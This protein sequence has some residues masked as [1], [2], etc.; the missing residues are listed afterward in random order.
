M[1]YFAGV[2]DALRVTFVQMMLIS[3]LA[4]GI[5]VV[6]MYINLKKWG[7]GS[8]GYGAAPSKSIMAFPKMLMYQ[9]NEHAHVHNQSVLETFVLDILFQRRILRRSPLRWFMHFTIFVGWMTLF[10]MSGAMFAVE[11]IHLIGEKVGY[12]HSLPWFMIP[13]TFRELLA[14][15]NDV[16]SYIL[17]IGIIIAIYR[18]LFVTKVREATIAYDSILLIGLTII[19][20]SGFV[21]DGI[22]TGR[23]WGLGIDSEL[24]PPMALFHVVISLLF[25]IAYI[26]FSKYIHVIAIPLA[27]LANKGGE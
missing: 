26:P 1:D 15:P 6:G 11:M 24:A 14:V 3:F 13:E 22:R 18:R 4:M 8:T 27:L 2:T 7:M 10:A 23:L 12:A 9:M 21:A 20:I 5:F 25:C 17:L 16:F 19:T